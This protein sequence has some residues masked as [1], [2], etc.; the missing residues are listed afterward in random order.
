MKQGCFPEPTVLFDVP[1]EARI[2]REAPFAPVAPLA[3][4]DTFDDVIKRANATDF[5]LAACV[6]T[7]DSALAPGA[8][9]LRPIH[10]RI[11]FRP[12]SGDYK[13]SQIE[14]EIERKH[15]RMSRNR[16]HARGFLTGCGFDHPH[17]FPRA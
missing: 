7:R 13:R 16:H 10:E 1:D 4:F 6:L 2:M 11:P 5:G 3:S 15:N 17:I 12:P 14:N 8:F 9:H